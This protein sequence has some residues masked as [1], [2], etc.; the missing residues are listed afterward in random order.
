MAP[1]ENAR[2]QDTGLV[3]QRP[4]HGNNA[5]VRFEKDRLHW[6]VRQKEKED[7]AIG[8]RDCPKDQEKKFP[9]GD[10]MRVDMTNAVGYQAT[11]EKRAAIPKV[12]CRLT[13]SPISPGPS[14]V[15]AGP[16]TG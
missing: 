1:P 16:L 10:Q 11:E 8:A 7:E 14:C 12:P 6:R 3:L 15:S 4:V 9:G 13:A 2:V 5:F